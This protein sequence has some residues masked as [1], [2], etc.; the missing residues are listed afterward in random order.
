MGLEIALG[1]MEKGVDCG[2]D[3]AGVTLGP[4]LLSGCPWFPSMEVQIPSAL[5]EAAPTICLLLPRFLPSVIRCE[6]KG[7]NQD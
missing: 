6:M 2:E 4:Q 1:L 5:L 3:G 7:G